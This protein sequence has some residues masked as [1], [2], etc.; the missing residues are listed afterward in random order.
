MIFLLL[1]RGTEWGLKGRD[2]ARDV[3]RVG[4]E[5]ERL[6]SHSHS[7]LAAGS[8]LLFVIMKYIVQVQ[9]T[10]GFHFQRAT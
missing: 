6:D 5:R 3:I 8:F 1:C 4:E 7:S 9:L 10:C 2:R